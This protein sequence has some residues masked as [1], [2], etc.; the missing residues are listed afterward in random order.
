MKK[1]KAAILALTLVYPTHI[2]GATQ[3]NKPEY[4]SC[5]AVSVVI[6]GVAT[7][8]SHCNGVTWWLHKQSALWHGLRSFV[9]VRK[10]YL[11]L[12]VDF[13]DRCN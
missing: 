8:C 7:P 4:Q 12:V 11:G 5:R 13:C 9:A 10:E 6:K 1:I 3:A 2:T